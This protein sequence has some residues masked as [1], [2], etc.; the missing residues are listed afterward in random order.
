MDGVECVS[1]DI[2]DSSVT[3]VFANG[4]RTVIEKIPSTVMSQMVQA[5]AAAWDDLATPPAIQ[6]G[7]E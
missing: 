6:E 5:L 2:A 3:L 1:L 7:N 4:D